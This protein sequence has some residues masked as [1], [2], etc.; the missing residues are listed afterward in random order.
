[1][2]KIILILSIGFAFISCKKNSGTTSGAGVS[3]TT[4][5]NIYPSNAT[6]FY[7]FLSLTKNQNINL[8]PNNPHIV[9]TN[10]AAN[11]VFNSS[12][13]P[14]N[15]YN[16][17]HLAVDSV[18]FNN[19]FCPIDT[20]DN[21]Y[22]S[23]SADSLCN[24]RIVGNNSIHSFNFTKNNG[25]AIYTGY[26]LLP[27]TID[28]TQPITLPIHIANADDVV[29]ILN[30]NGTGPIDTLKPGAT[31]AAFSTTQMSIGHTGMGSI[32]IQNSNY[33]AENVYGKPMQ[34]AFFL[35]FEKQVYFK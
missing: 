32:L 23:G 10:Y 31:S 4:N 28:H 25:M 34:F 3:T 13:L 20:F 22:N 6:D 26:N 1:M 2:K 27:D 5:S 18:F 21:S 30:M 11:A 19:T 17:P 29:V 16:V 24:W 33:Y 15:F 9:Y 8:S 7:G 12:P 14:I 35:Y